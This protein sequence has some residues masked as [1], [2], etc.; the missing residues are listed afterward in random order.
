[1]STPEIKINSDLPAADLIQPAAISNGHVRNGG[2]VRV[3]PPAIDPVSAW[4][5]YVN[6]IIGAEISDISRYYDRLIQYRPRSEDLGILRAAVSAPQKEVAES[7]E[8]LNSLNAERNNRSLILINGNFNHDFDIQETLSSL[9]NNVSRTTRIVA[10]LYNPYYRWLYRLANRL[11]IRSGEEPETFLTRVDLENICRLSGFE[12]VRYRPAAYCPWPLFGFGDLINRIFPAI[13]G[14]RWLNLATLAVLRP[15]L[16]DNSKPSLSIIIPARNEKGN[17]ENALS[18]LPDFGSARIEVIFVEGHSTDG[19]WPEIKRVVPIYQDRFTV[20]AVQQAG[21]GKC[22]AVRLGFSLASGDLLTILDADLS[23]PPELLPRFYNA[24]CEGQADF[25]NGSRLV[26]PIEG[27]AMRFLNR[28][29]NIFFSKALSFVLGIRLGDS[30]CGTKLLA[31]HDYQRFCRWRADFG[32]FD[33]F[34][35]FELLFPAAQLGLGVIDVAIRYRDRVYG[36]TNIRRFYHGMMLLRM[37]V[38]GLIRMKFG[39]VPART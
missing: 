13:P 25:I 37:T 39:K 34:G 17:I 4:R 35:D 21:K 23:M 15:N 7:V 16:P 31:R 24:W 1:M 5:R 3:E 9:R 14:L 22:D 38:I 26:Y 20:R 12:V 11:G 32:D 27:K 36:S 33:P 28:C 30:L 19:T 2:S 8:Q 10:V 18:R 29:G 6:S